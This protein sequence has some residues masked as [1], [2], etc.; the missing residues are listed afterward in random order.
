MVKAEIQI[1]HKIVGEICIHCE[2][3]YQVIHDILLNKL[4]TR[5]RLYSGLTMPANRNGENDQNN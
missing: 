5:K 3:R 2:P 1:N 4:L